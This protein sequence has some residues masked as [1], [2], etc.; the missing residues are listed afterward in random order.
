VIVDAPQSSTPFQR[1]TVAAEKQGAMGL[2][3]VE[4]DR[5]D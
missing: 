4:A 3:V 2:S 5:D 1:P